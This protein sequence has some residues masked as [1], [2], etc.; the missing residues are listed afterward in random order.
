MTATVPLINGKSYGW[1]S[2]KF[3]VGGVPFIGITKINYSEDQEITDNYGAGNK[4]I[5]RGYGKIKFDGSITLY[6]DEVERLT[7]QSPTGRL[8]DLG[9]FDITVSYLKGTA[10]VNHTLLACAFKNNHR[11]TQEGDTSIP[12]ELKLAIGDIKWK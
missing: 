1:S 6:A 12:V 8:Q 7:A 10:I 4:P 11:D 9:E 5:S 2:I 3:G